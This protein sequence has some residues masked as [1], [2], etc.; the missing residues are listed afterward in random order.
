MQLQS[1]LAIIKPGTNY[2]TAWHFKTPHQIGE[3][4]SNGSSQPVEPKFERFH[5]P[6]GKGNSNAG[7][8]KLQRSE[9][10]ITRLFNFETHRRQNWTDKKNEEVE[11]PN[12]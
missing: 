2:P 5:K 10:A 11:T 8:P 9:N 12:S 1:G 3:G 6:K 7:S 4:M